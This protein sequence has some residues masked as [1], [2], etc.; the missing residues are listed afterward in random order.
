MY[1]HTRVCM[2]IKHVY[3]IYVHVCIFKAD[4]KYSDLVILVHITVSRS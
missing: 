4:E 1:A 3:I 2:Y